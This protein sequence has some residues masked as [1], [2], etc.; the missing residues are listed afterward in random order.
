MSPT[1]RTIG[2]R[3]SV[4]LTVHFIN[5]SVIARMEKCTVAV[6][7]ESTM[8]PDRSE[9][10][11]CHVRPHEVGLLPKQRRVQ[12]F[13][14][15]RCLIWR[16]SCNGRRLFRDM[17]RRGTLPLPRR[18]VHCAI[19]LVMRGVFMR[20]RCIRSRA[21][22]ISRACPSPSARNLPRP[23]TSPRHSS[24]RRA[25]V[26]ERRSAPPTRAWNYGDALLNPPLGAHPIV[27]GTLGLLGVE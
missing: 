23:K 5:L 10:D 8:P 22:H 11:L 16:A 14:R 26:A 7:R 1:T 9:C 17:P 25:I 6:F 4:T 3:F 27:H 12:S 18:N 19:A 2:C 20:L 13:R 21:G 15:R 24:S